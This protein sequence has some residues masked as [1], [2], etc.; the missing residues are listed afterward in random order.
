MKIANRRGV[1]KVP[2]LYGPKV[3]RPAS[4]GRVLPFS[5]TDVAGLAIWVRGDG[6]LWQDTG[7]ITPAT[8]NSQPVAVWDD[9]SGNNR[10][11]I[12]A[13]GTKQP[14]LMTN[15]RSGLPAVRF[16][17]VDDYLQNIFTLNQPVT[18]FCVCRWPII[19]RY[20][21]DGTGTPTGAKGSIGH[22]TTANTVRLHGGTALASPAGITASAWILISWVLNGNSSEVFLNGVSAVAGAAGA[23]VMAGLTLG[24]NS[25]FTGASMG[26]DIGEVLLYSGALSTT[27][28][29]SVENHL[30]AKWM[31]V[32]EPY[33]VPGCQVWLRGDNPMY[34]DN[35]GTLPISA[36][37]DPVGLWLSKFGT[38]TFGAAQASTTSPD[39]RPKLKLNVIQ[40]KNV[41]RFDGVDDWL[42]TG[43][44]LSSIV[45][46]ASGVVYCVFRPNGFNNM[47]PATETGN[48]L[49]A[50]GVWCDAT[51]SRMGL[52][53]TGTTPMLHA[54]NAETGPV[55]ADF[56]RQALSVNTWHMHRWRHVGGVLYSKRS[57]LPEVSVP[58][59]NWSVANQLRL[60]ANWDGTFP[61]NV[62][63]A[64][65][66]GYNVDPSPADLAAL[67]LY[68]ARRYQ[69]S[70]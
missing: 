18:G 53:M 15:Q 30:L 47:N 37:G 67:D 17:A 61:A 44:N 55:D 31:Q 38:S 12:N 5:P 36:D 8:A 54:V 19:N 9:G 34:S 40:G 62:D 58:S 27:D 64:E 1:L 22:I 43:A 14:L 20:I 35:A 13:T 50:D 45:S 70:W 21:L 29:Q 10:H 11:L 39:R 56:A 66:I 60:G 7:R 16:D 25:G 26:S 69:I 63:I 6:T 52:T 4:R 51:T 3:G 59:G 28:R 2:S 33:E 41:V 57:G 32:K 48:A 24:T 49:L 23:N 68:L 65:W 46:A 42:Q